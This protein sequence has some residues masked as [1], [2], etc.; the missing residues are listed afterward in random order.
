MFENKLINIMNDA[1]P[2][3]SLW[4]DGHKIPWDDP[5]FSGRMLREHL[6]QDH[7][8]ASRTVDVIAQQ[9]AW[10][11]QGLLGR[12]AGRVLDLGCGPGLYA[13]H[14]CQA[15]H[16]YRGI[17][18]GPAAIAYAQRNFTADGQGEFMLCDV[19][20]A[21]F[22]EAHDLVMMLYGELNVFPP[23]DCARILAKAYAALKPGGRI[24]LEV[25]TREAVMASGRNC[26]WYK[27]AG[28]LFSDSPH[29]CLTET[30]W[31]PDQAVALQVFQVVDLASGGLQT[32]RSTMQAYADD[33]YCRSL[34][35]AGFK[36]VKFHPDWP[37]HSQAL[38]AISAIKK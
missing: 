14:L 29:L 4:T 38:L 21:D 6:S 1:P 18:F 22:G 2:V 13:P 8:L 36:K 32:Y 9:A 15:G 23:R 7:D 34:S 17:D 16:A 5:Q 25:H 19:R 12:G 26:S 33:D 31:Y 27:S 3:D 24:F 28:G 35:E 30:H 20:Q 11:A 10:L 37:A